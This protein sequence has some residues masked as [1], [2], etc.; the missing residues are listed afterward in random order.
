MVNLWPT[1]THPAT[2]VLVHRFPTGSAL[3]HLLYSN[4]PEN[5]NSNPPQLLGK[6]P[7]SRKQFGV[8]IFSFLSFLFF[9]FFTSSSHPLL[10]L[11]RKTLAP[12]LHPICR[13]CPQ[14]EIFGGV[15]YSGILIL[16]V[17]MRRNVK[18]WHVPCGQTTCQNKQPFPQTQCELEALFKQLNGNSFHIL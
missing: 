17:S 16:D 4:P 9:P 7:G 12:A 14:E 3:S 6:D 15:V 13:R 5:R 2:H 18:S 11:P 8:Y 10:Y 1:E